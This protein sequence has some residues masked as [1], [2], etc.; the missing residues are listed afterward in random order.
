[1]RLKELGSAL[2][3]IEEAFERARQIPREKTL[4]KV[5]QEN[6]RQNRVIKFDPRLPDIR[7]ILKRAWT[8]LVEDNK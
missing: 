6:E 4:E 2:A 5:V 3:S 7:S 8:A 1:M